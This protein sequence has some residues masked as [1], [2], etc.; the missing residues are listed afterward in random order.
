MAPSSVSRTYTIAA[1]TALEANQNWG[2]RNNGA[3]ATTLVGSGPVADGDAA[4]G[5]SNAGAGLRILSGAS[6]FD[7]SSS[8]AAGGGLRVGHAKGLGSP[9]G[10]T[11]VASNGWIE[12]VGNITVPEPLTLR[13]AC[14]AGALRAIGGTNVWSGPVA[15]AAPTRLRASPGCLLSLSGGVSGACDLL[16]S[17]EAGG[18]LALCGSPVSLPSRKILAYGEG[19]VTLASTGN[20]YGTLEVA[21]AG[22]RLRMGASNALSSGSTLSVGAGYSAQG[23]VD[24]NG[25]DQ[26]VA[27]LVRGTTGSSTNRIVTSSSPATLTVNET[28]SSAIYFNGHLTGALGLTK[29]GSG[30]LNLTGNNNTYSGET[31]VN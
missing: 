28:S 18:E 21:G 20:A 29:G 3:G 9:A 4:F 13:D 10:G 5:I 8:V 7:G 27:R 22:M 2:V 14:S 17:P 11:D 25:Y 15:L 30:Y 6:D 19:T 12:V 26:T 31:T 24:L 1:K 23:V 16:L